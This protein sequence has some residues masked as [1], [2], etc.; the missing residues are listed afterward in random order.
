MNPVIALRS[1]L[2]PIQVLSSS[3]AFGYNMDPVIASNQ[4][5]NYSFQ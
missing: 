5:E 4:Y 2:K 1:L 3:I